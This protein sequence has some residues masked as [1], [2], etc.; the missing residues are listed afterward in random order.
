MQTKLAVAVI[1]LLTVLMLVLVSF[2][3]MAG[4]ASNHPDF[5]TASFQSSGSNAT[6][7]NTVD[8]SLNYTVPANNITSTSVVT[9]SNWTSTGKLI[10][11]VMSNSSIPEIAKL[12]PNFVN[13]PR[14]TDNSYTPLYTSGA[15]PY[16]IGSYGVYN[17][18][19]TLKNYTYYTSSFEGSLT[20]NNASEL[21]LSSDSPTSYSIQLNTVLSNVTLF[22]TEGY[23]FWTQNVASYDFTTHSITLIDNIWNLSS[24]T[25]VVNG[26]EFHNYT[27][28]PSPGYFYY[29]IGPTM[30][31]SYPFTLNLYL[32]TT[33]ID[34]YN[35]VFFNFSLI[36]NGKTHSGSYDRVEFNSTGSHSSALK[37][38]A[39]FEV[40]GSRLTD[41]NFLPMDAEMIIGGPGGG[42][43]AT[44][45][46]FS[47]TMGLS[48]FNGT[49]YSPV[50]SAYGAGS[51]TGETSIG[52]SEYYT[53]NTA[54]LSSGPSFVQGLWNV[55]DKPGY[56]SVSGKLS[57]SNAFI[58][59]S[60]TAIA[61][62]STAQ[63]APSPVNGSFDYRLQNGTYSMEALLSYHDQYFFNNVTKNGN[64]SLAVKLASNISKGL[65]TPL[66]ASDNSQ[67]ANISIKGVGTP[68]DPYI[69]PGPGYV[70]STIQGLPDH[71][72]GLFSQV[73]DYLFPSFYGILIDNTTAY[74]VFTGFRSAN[75]N[76]PFQIQ[77]PYNLTES[78]ET[79]YGGV[80]TNSL[81]MAFYDSSNIVVNNSVI[82]GW[83]PSVNFYDVSYYNIP[84]VASLIFWNTTDSLI[85][86]NIVSS[87]GTGILLYGTNGYSMG[88]Y[89]WNNTF[90]NDPILPTGGFYSNAPVGLTVAAG[91][92]TVYNNIFNT[93]VPVVSISGAYQNIYTGSWANYTNYFNITKEPSSD[94]MQFLGVNLTGSILGLDYQGGNYYYNY[95]GNGSQPYN[96]TGV[97]IAL[98]GLTALDGSISY[99]YD[100]SPLVLPGQNTEIFAAHLP[101]GQ[102]TYFDINNAIYEIRA[103]TYAQLHLPDGAY[104]LLGFDLVNSNVQFQPTTYLGTVELQSGY[105]V[106]SGPVLDLS[107]NY[108][109]YYNL[110][111]KETGLPNGTLW[112]FTVPQAGIGYSLTA[113]NQSLFVKAGYFDVLPQSVDGYS[114]S[115][116][117]GYMSGAETATIQYFSISSPSVS[118]NYSVT[119]TENGLPGNTVW[120]VDIN[121][122]T[123]SSNSSSFE[124][125]GV[126]SGS[127]SF[128]VLSVSGYASHGSGTF[129]VNSGN[130][131]VSI[132]FDKAGSNLD[133]LEYLAAGIVIGA[134][135]AG[136]ALRLRRKNS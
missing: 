128:A 68:S 125:T 92:N 42:S 13:G 14:K 22:G 130:A 106:V 104:Q 135:A 116:L 55:S 96:G 81:G 59:F 19:G 16:G 20:I 105:F 4:N 65:Y 74:S 80:M 83:F 5:S 36:S 100:Y 86:D 35:T 58:F 8:S 136:V 28:I 39:L 91:G 119:F 24:P 122:K 49:H 133:Y 115:S 57:P 63:W 33:T 131:S 129:I 70:N 99:T 108:N 9:N 47:G 40:S 38:P 62:N 82:S 41:T 72:M 37:S 107:L 23:Q 46:N 101:A 25:A 60:K 120:G 77:Y 45:Q 66:Y 10:A 117:Y 127:Y 123:Y 12:P 53:G 97:G 113:S 126:P 51:D 67:L 75:G 52:I 56:V 15:A 110:T 94:F 50:R 73:N 7:Y 98:N 29:K 2:S 32:N 48:F 71:I 89:V 64:A 93:T 30:P 3:F 11:G 124:I 102:N 61:D 18:G 44:F 112:G 27:G 85:A 95:F 21:Y 132:L 121:G 76:S 54:Y 134:L 88:D 111:V 84:T 17:S 31:A 78:I 43:T 69:I 109:T 34:G 6:S 87:Q 26:N 79:I 103:G 1:A 114:T 90:R 118:H